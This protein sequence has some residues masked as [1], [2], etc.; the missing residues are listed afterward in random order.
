MARR[1]VLA[2]LQGFLKECAW[3]TIH[4]HKFTPLFTLDKCMIQLLHIKNAIVVSNMN[5]ATTT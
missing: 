5:M 2:Q 3:Y 1:R 4:L